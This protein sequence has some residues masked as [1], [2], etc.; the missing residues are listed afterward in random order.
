MTLLYLFLP[1]TIYLHFSK[2]N[3]I[4]HYIANSS[5]KFNN[6]CISLIESLNR[7]ISSQN[8]KIHTSNSIKEAPIFALQHN[9]IKS[10]IKKIK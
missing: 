6:N 9:S 5:H 2:L 10:L 3:S 4:P 7:Q 8:T 1:K